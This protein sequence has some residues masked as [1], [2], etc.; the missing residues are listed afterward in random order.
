RATEAERR[1]R[2]QLGVALYTRKLDR[3]AKRLLGLLSIAGAALHLAQ[4][5]E[6]VDLENRVAR[7]FQLEGLQ[8]TLVMTRGIFVRYERS[9]PIPRAARVLDCLPAVVPRLG[10]LE[11][12]VCELGEVRLGLRGIELFEHLP[13][14]PMRPHATD[15]A[16]L[17]IERF[18]QQLV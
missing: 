11:E 10:R 14:L 3:V 13:D 18:A 17:G 16:H 7:I 5:E 2:E 8:R 12:V 1:L 4:G 9:R 15:G 6:K